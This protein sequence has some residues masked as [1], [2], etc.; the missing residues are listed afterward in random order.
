MAL[1][2]PDI[3]IELLLNDARNSL[4]LEDTTGLYSLDNLLGYNLPGGP[5]VNS[6]ISVTVTINYTQLSANLVYVFTISSGTITVCTI[7]FA[8]STPVSIISLI[9]STVWPFTSANRFEL[10]ADYG[11][12]LPPLDDMVYEASY[13]V[14]G[15]YS[16]EA[17]NYTGEKQELM[18]V[19]T[20]CCISKALVAL[21]INNVT[22][23]ELAMKASGY[24]MTAH[25]ANEYGNTVQ[26]NSYINRAKNICES[27]C[28]CGC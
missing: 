3:K 18:D 8:G 21:D 5:T 13:Q 24:L 6:V 17:F 11:V 16:A 20:T 19:A 2:A 1:N 7:S 25:S 14:V 28:N 23:Q 9:A 4:F 12:T 27:I 22:G 15:T 26:S 10:T